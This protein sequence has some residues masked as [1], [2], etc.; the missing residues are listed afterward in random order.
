MNLSVHYLHPPKEEFQEYLREKLVP[1]VE[2]TVGDQGPIPPGTVILIAGRP[3]QEHLEL[4][5]NLRTLIIPWS[6]LPDV[7]RELLLDYPHISVHNLHHNAT[8]VAELA[9]TLLLAA[10][11]F[12]VPLDRS[13][14]AGDWTPRYRPSK[15]MLLKGKVALILG[16]GA[17]GQRLARL[18]RA[19]QMRVLA[20]KRQPD[21]GNGEPGVEI[22]PPTS[23]T[24]LLPA[25]DALLI[26]LPHT[27]E[28][29]GLIG[30]DE[31]AMLPPGAVLVNVGRGP[32]VDEEALYLALRDGR[33]HAAGLDVW[34]NYPAEEADRPNT[35][36]TAYPFHEL[37]NVVMSPHRGGATTET[38][39]LRMESLAKTL[40][41]A[42]SG[43]SLPN[44]VDI[45]AGY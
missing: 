33:L 25:A 20:T 9:F 10:A 13:L 43:Q 19:M 37:D 26:C 22:Y 38:N 34:Y 29:D 24:N 4:S 12:I 18:C 39:Y 17:I 21:P 7:T 35:P 3:K 28:T 1:S 40:N 32:I 16:Y 23:L 42:A 5:S 30:S 6:G 36:P 27:P 8:P 45:A 41:A 14:R 44:R 15:S 31:L 2:L 11:K